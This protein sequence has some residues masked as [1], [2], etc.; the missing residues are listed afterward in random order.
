MLSGVS[1]RHFDLD[2]FVGL[3][4]THYDGKSSCYRLSAIQN[5]D[6]QSAH[7]FRSRDEVKDEG[8]FWYAFRKELA[9]IVNLWRKVCSKCSR[10]CFRWL[11]CMNFSL[12][13]A[14]RQRAF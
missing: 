8:D 10:V 9:F 3:R 13:L 4:P 1:L 2:G 12:R 7:F 14:L 5:L 11:L 6:Q